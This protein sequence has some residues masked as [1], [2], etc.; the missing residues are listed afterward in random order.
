MNSQI[1]LD[2]YLVNLMGAFIQFLKVGG[3]LKKVAICQQ[4]SIDGQKV[5]GGLGHVHQEN[6]EFVQL[7][8]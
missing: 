1:T 2:L 4:N 6:L 8:L 7:L 3:C 5:W